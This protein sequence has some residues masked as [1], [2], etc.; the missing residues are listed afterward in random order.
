MN[1]FTHRPL[2]NPA[3]KMTEVLNL[4]TSLLG[5]FNRLGLKLGFGEA[6]VGEVCGEAGIDPETFLLICRV[7]AFEGYMPGP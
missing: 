1:Q 4:D 3:M 5:V 2:L 7:Y 6:S